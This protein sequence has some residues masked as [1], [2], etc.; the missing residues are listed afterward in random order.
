MTELCLLVFFDHHSLNTVNFSLS[1]FTDRFN[2][3]H[4]MTSFKAKG[5]CVLPFLINS[6]T[7]VTVCLR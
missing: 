4:N 5:T 7:T 3:G 1:D 6:F 2:V